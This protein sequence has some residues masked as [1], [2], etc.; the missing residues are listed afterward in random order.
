MK[1]YFENRLY[2]LFQKIVILSF[3]YNIFLLHKV[4]I[5]MHFN[6]IFTRIIVVI[7]KGLNSV[8][9][10]SLNKKIHLL[11]LIHIKSMGIK[12]SLYIYIYMTYYLL[13]V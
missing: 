13:H 9:L 4:Q 10:L 7:Q 5:I 11:T 8:Y 6:I 2:L 3:Q 1:K 12:V